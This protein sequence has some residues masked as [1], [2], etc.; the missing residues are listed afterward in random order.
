MGRIQ[1]QE[2]QS[3]GNA[4]VGNDFGEET[5]SGAGGN[6]C[7]GLGHFGLGH[8][9]GQ[10]RTGA[11]LGAFHAGA[12]GLGHGFGHGLFRILHQ[13][14]GP[15]GQGLGDLG[16]QFVPA[17]QGM[18][19]AEEGNGAT[20]QIG[21]PV[22]VPVLN[23]PGGLEDPHA[24]EGHI[25]HGHGPLGEVLNPLGKGLCLGFG[26]LFHLAPGGQ[27][28]LEAV[29]EFGDF[30]F[31]PGHQG[32][33]FQAQLLGV[34]FKGKDLVQILIFIGGRAQG[35][36][37]ELKGHL[38][39][40]H[41]HA[42]FV[43]DVLFTDAENIARMVGELFIELVGNGLVNAL[44]VP[45]HGEL[46]RHGLEPAQGLPH[47]GL[48]HHPGTG[49][50][51]RIL[52]VDNAGHRRFL[53]T[54]GGA[55]QHRLQ[56]G[57]PHGIQH[58][59]QCLGQIPARRRI[60]RGRTGEVL[61]G[62]FALA[63]ESAHGILVAILESGIV[64][65]VAEDIAHIQVQFRMLGQRLDRG[66]VGAVGNASQFPHHVGKMGDGD[67]AFVDPGHQ[68]RQMFG[69][70]TALV[71]S[72]QGLDH[73][74]KFFRRGGSAGDGK[75]RCPI[76]QFLNQGIV[77]LGASQGRVGVE[78][79][80]HLGRGK[81]GIP[82]EAAPAVVVEQGFQGIH[83]GLVARGLGL[84]KG[85]LEFGRKLKGLPFQGQVGD[86]Q[87]FTGL[88]Q[89]YQLIGEPGL[90]E[91]GKLGIGDPGQDLQTGLGNALG[92]A[93]HL[94]NGIVAGPPVR[95]I[96]FPGLALVP[97]FHHGVDLSVHQGQGKLGIWIDVPEFLGTGN[98]GQIRRGVP[99]GLPGFGPGKLGVQ[100][101]MGIIQAQVG[102]LNE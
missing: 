54:A 72:G 79:L 19:P 83:H 90:L 9:C 52:G 25:G 86:F 21:G 49:T 37:L 55:F 38:F 73:V 89:C 76:A 31:V 61:H 3:H 74:G 64:S 62:L 24:H 91:G 70:G 53:R 10:C 36:E 7:P 2:D 56:F 93:D 34:Q 84:V 99:P 60:A 27:F 32:L 102:H 15:G 18:D 77:G 8:A 46:G 20:A 66:H 50:Q 26:P 75:I 41:I 47:L 51:G 87:V 1:P 35:F 40:A 94:D 65:D 17:L 4:H 12:R 80:A 101:M 42:V 33:G 14:L 68:G 63:L 16:G 30:L 6:A 67:Q 69:Q 92:P 96:D 45:D 28:G 78:Q 39:R 98:G 71:L 58:R 22:G 57:L 23:G 5:G 81:A 13:V 43:Q 85:F 44:D 48:G 59:F 82:E 88:H 97:Q 29:A 11:H 100:R 95:G